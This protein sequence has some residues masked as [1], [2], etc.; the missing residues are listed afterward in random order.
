MKENISIVTAIIA[1]IIS[2]I[3]II[4]AV[5]VK[6]EATVLEN[7]I[8]GFEL[9][10]NSIASNHIIDETIKLNDLNSEV[11]A[12]MTGVVNIIDNSITSSA[13][14]NGSVYNRHVADDAG[15]APSKIL[16]TAWTQNNDGAD[17][18]LDADTLDTIEGSQFLRN[19]QSGTLDGDLTVDSIQYSSP[20]THYYTV[21]AKHFKPKGLVDYNIG[22]CGAFY[23]LES[24][25]AAY[26]PVFLPDGAIITSVTGF[27]RDTSDEYDI[28]VNLQRDFL[29]SCGYS[30][31]A[32]FTGNSDTG[33]YNVTYSSIIGNPIDNQKH[34][35]SISIYCEKWDSNIAFKGAIIEYTIE[36]V[37]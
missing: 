21:G 37:D 12:S 1:I 14:A 33:Y 25:G 2:F 9:V 29:D 36:E 26:A 28:T 13:L 17:S 3:A 31:M 32:Y 30:G 8:N 35:Y 11:I 19:D 16:G 18:G 34:S 24:T 6:P 15:I 4:S 20:R 5:L 23:L 22:G 7:E 10:D 27:F